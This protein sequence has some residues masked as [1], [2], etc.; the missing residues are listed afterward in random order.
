VWL[1]RSPELASGR[2][3][4][5]LALGQHL[6]D[7]MKYVLTVIAVLLATAANAQAPTCKSQIAEKKL[8]GEEL[9]SFLTK[10][11]SDA[12]AACEKSA[13]DKNLAGTAKTSH[14]KKCTDDA[15][16]VLRLGGRPHPNNSTSARRP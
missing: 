13:A 5:R 7:P 14:V 9:K 1:R 15:V 16:G 3:Q 12:A 11:R 4:R 10:C 8:E 2:R 6:S